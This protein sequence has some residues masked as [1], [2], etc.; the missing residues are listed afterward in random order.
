VNVA[1]YFLIGIGVVVLLF[2]LIAVFG[3]RGESRAPEPQR[4]RDPMR[5]SEYI[6]YGFIL[7][8]AG[9][10]LIGAALAIKND[11]SVFLMPV[12]IVLATIGQ[13]FLLVGI[14]A[15]GVQVGNWWSE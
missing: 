6:G 2:V 5:I 13:I 11:V 7:M 9:G 4:S 3:G 8:L 15:K 14:V 1:V 10:G 12:G